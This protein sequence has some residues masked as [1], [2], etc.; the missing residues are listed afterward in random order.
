MNTILKWASWV[1]TAGASYLI[2][3]GFLSYIIGNTPVFGVKYG[4]YLLFGGYLTLF[5]IMVI[6]LK[7][8]CQE[9]T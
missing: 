8:S 5:G 1:V 4:T 7:I 9:K 2:I 6:L 3:L